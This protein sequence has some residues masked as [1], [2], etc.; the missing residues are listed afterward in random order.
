MLKKGI[1][2]SRNKVVDSDEKENK[3]QVNT[4][5]NSNKRSDEKEAAQIKTTVED[6]EDSKSNSYNDL[7]SNDVVSGFLYDKLQKEVINL[8]KSCEIKESSLQTKEEEIKVLVTATPTALP[9]VTLELKIR[10]ILLFSDAHKES[11]CTDKGYGNRVEENE[12]G[13]SCQRQGGCF[14]KIR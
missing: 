4:G 9:L 13:S 11:R 5:M 7:G 6:D 3:M 14:N 12:K 10:N 2:A 8:R 1:W